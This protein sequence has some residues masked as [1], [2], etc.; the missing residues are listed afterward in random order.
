MRFFLSTLWRKSEHSFALFSYSFIKF[1]VLFFFRSLGPNYFMLARFWRERIGTRTILLHVNSKQ[2]ERKLSQL[3]PTS[4]RKL[5]Q[6]KLAEKALHSLRGL[7]TA[8]FLGFY[9]PDRGGD[10]NDRPLRNALDLT[11]F[12]QGYI[13]KRLCFKAAEGSGGSKFAALN[14]VMNEGRLELHHPLSNEVYS[15]AEWTE[16]L[17]NFR[18]G[19]IIEEYLTQHSALARLNPDSVNTL[20]LIVIHTKDGFVTRGGMLRVGRAGSQVDN[21]STGGLACP[22]DIDTGR[23]VEALDL[24]IERNSYDAHPDTGAIL[25]GFEIPF[26]P[27][28]IE[29]ANRAVAAFPQMNFCGIDIAVTPSGPIVIELNSDP[30]RR[31]AA[32]M[33]LPHAK[34]FAEGVKCSS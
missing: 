22:I 9:H 18:S 1:V 14:V 8:A 30:D 2:Y 4:F 6:H 25:K 13:E 24:S 34:L 28:C 19:T 26:W 20:R 23:V 15:V 11:A 17:K 5:S 32:H 31:F 12:L 33:D 7:P 29:L 10:T 16:R 27:E 3:N 21:T